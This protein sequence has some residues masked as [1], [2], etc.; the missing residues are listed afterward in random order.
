M[1]KKIIN[2]LQ[3][4]GLNA[5]GY[6]DKDISELMGINRSSISSRRIMLNLKPNRAKL[7]DHELFM[8]FY[9]QNFSDREI[10]EKTNKSFKSIQAYRLSLGLTPNKKN[11]DKMVIKDKGELIKLFN[12]GYS[13]KKI[14]EILKLNKIT[15]GINLRK[16]GLKASIRNKTMKIEPS[17]REKSIMI[18]TLLGD[19]SM[20]KS[21][22]I[23]LSHSIKQLEY[24]EFKRN[25]LK[26][27]S[28]SEIKYSE[29][30]DK[31]TERIYFISSFIIRSTEFG[32]SIFNYLY[33]DK[34]IISKEILK[35]YNEEAMAI[36]F[37]DDGCMA[38]PHNVKYHFFATNAFDY[39]SVSLLKEHM[40][41]KFNLNT[42]IQIVGKN[43]D[44][45]ELC[46]VGKESNKNFEN[47]IKPYCIESMYYKI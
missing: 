35:Y 15:V 31:R 32:K 13:I 19:A 12:L 20:Q 45:Y 30:K 9:N 16:L 27:I 17:E 21:G 7:I 23:T 29:R 18:G 22:L 34:K 26:N 39:N 43:K 37:M 25:L 46:I 10:C 33:N 1:P 28:C 41:E 11:I 42:R 8:L 44:Q 40:K 24:I 5:N 36:H 3:L 47:I 2:D 6:S 38:K 14:A 4:I